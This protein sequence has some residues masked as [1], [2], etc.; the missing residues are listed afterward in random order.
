MTVQTDR[1]KTQ[2]KFFDNWAEFSQIEHSWRQLHAQSNSSVFD[3]FEWLKIQE[4]VLER[5]ETLRMATLWEG[6]DLIAG[7]ALV[8]THQ[9][10]SKAVKAY[11]PPTL[12]LMH[13][14]YTGFQSVIARDEDAAA[15]L[16]HGVCKG[17]GKPNVSLDMIRD[18]G[19]M[20]SFLSA[21]NTANY[22]TVCTQ[23]FESVLI[24][25]DQTYDAYLK[26]RSGN[27]RKINKRAMR[28]LASADVH[29]S[30][31]DP[32][33][34]VTFDRILDVSRRTW[35]HAA[36]TGIAAT[37]QNTAFVQRMLSQTDEIK[38]FV[39]FLS[40]PDGDV[41]SIIML[42]FRDTVYTVWSEFDEA[43]EHLSP[44]R[45]IVT[46]GIR[47]LLDNAVGG[48]IDLMRKTHFTRSFSEETYA[49]EHF[50]AFPKFGFSHLLYTTDAAARRI[51][52]SVHA[53]KRKT[54]RRVDVMKALVKKAADT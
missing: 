48:T 11:K 14:H 31:V 10:L 5:R 15:Q 17:S 54:I 44:G 41:A 6:E 30:I 49:I 50:R 29:F 1:Q 25:G 20:R 38:P 34:P 53:G 46:L 4:S 27:F 40:G 23:R 42:A 36:G 7:V 13:W 39:G 32:A 2:L 8:D 12:A 16:A 37:P 35:K 43:Y 22:V 24:A 45:N 18:E 26:S 28:A 52:R 19:I 33:D 3:C 9:P 51:V 47:Y 21:F